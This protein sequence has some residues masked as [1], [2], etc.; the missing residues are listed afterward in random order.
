LLKEK[1]HVFFY[2][3]GV[4]D[5]PKQGT[6]ITVEGS[7]GNEEIMTETSSSPTQRQGDSDPGARTLTLTGFKH[8]LREIFSRETY[9]SFRWIS[10]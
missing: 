8:L 3:K 6:V 10:R 4:L 7:P 1:T 5:P 9:M 2:F